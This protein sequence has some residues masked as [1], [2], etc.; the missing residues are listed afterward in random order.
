MHESILKAPGILIAEA[1]GKPAPRQLDG[2]QILRGVAAA[3][4]V[5]SHY[6]LVFVEYGGQSIIASYH[7]LAFV[8][9]SGVDIFFCISGFVII[10]SLLIRPH[11]VNWRAFGLARLKR[12]IP[13][14]WFFTL[15]MVGMWMTGRA[16]TKLAL[17]PDL[18]LRSLLLLPLEKHVMGEPVSTHPILDQGWTLQYEALFYICCAVV[19][20]LVGSKRVFP[21]TPVA[22]AIL[23]VVSLFIPAMP[24]YL[25]DPLMLEFVGGTILGWLAATGRLFRLPWPRAIAWGSI[26][27][28]VMG[29]L[30]TTFVPNPESLRVLIWGVPGFL[31]VLGSILVTPVRGGRLVDAGIFL[32]AASYSIYL[33]HGFATIFVG[34]MMKKGYLVGAGSVVLLVVTAVTVAGTAMVYPLIERPITKFLR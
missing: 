10:Y 7:S 22:V 5:F 12:I 31:I 8:G 19:I 24:A 9:A 29:L 13:L 1:E 33:G 27:L 11:Q 28:G 4:V 26:A 25:H 18:V 32:G 21:W 30:L 15:A 20:A 17:P 23:A 14:Y 2:V 16:L 6:C 3:L 34:T